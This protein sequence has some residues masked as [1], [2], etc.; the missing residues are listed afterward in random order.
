M[1]APPPPTHGGARADAGSTRAEQWREAQQGLSAGLRGKL[2]LEEVRAA[3]RRDAQAIF[4]GVWDRLNSGRRSLGL[5]TERARPAAWES[6]NLEHTFRLLKQTLGWT[7]PRIRSAQAT[8][9][10]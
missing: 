8:A 2:A 1:V 4:D 3:A 7:A 6:I 9:L 5:D 10:S